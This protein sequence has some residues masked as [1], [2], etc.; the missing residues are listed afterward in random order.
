MEYILPLLAAAM[1]VGVSKGGLSSAGALA[2]PALSLT[3]NPIQAAA[4]LLPVYIATDWIAVWLYRRDFSARNLKIMIPGMLL[5]T[6]TAVVIIPYTPESALLVFT[7]LIGL[8]YCWR[9]WFTK[10]GGVKQEARVGPGLFWGWLT[11]ITSFIT[12]SGAPPSQAFLLPQQMPRLVFAG[13][14]AIAFSVGNLSKL[15]GYYA[16]GQLRILDWGMTLA[17]IA[18]GA[19]GTVLGRW[20]VA[21]LN[22]VHY[23]RVIEV[24]LLLLSVMLITKGLSL[25]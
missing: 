22:D 10:A 9:S 4:V 14:M 12:H 11:G 5:G 23:R 25:F 15:P 1:I 3:M 24:L 8:W 21:R 16:L 2:V 17:L 13:T 20:A 19:V 18:A 7:G 6:L